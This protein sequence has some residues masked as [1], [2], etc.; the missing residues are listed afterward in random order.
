VFGFLDFWISG[1]LGFGNLKDLG[2]FGIFGF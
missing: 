1:F 2:I